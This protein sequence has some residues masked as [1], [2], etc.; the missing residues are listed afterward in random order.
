MCGCNKNKG[1][2][3]VGRNPATVKQQSINNGVPKIPP[4]QLG[5]QALA[6]KNEPS[7]LTKEQRDIEKKRRAEL[8]RRKFGK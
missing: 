5:I 3:N 1:L 8:A 2:R 4:R 6:K 7:T